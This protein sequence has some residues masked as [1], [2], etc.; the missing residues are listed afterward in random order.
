MILGSLRLLGRAHASVRTTQELTNL[1]NVQHAAFG[2]LGLLA[3]TIRWFDLRGLIP[4][5]FGRLA[6]ALLFILLGMLMAFSYR[7]AV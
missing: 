3:G 4:R 7:E 5:D 1:V 2:S 6:C